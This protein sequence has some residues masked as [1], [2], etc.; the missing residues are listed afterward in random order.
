MSVRDDVLA[1]LRDPAAFAAIA[2]DPGVWLA[3]L[4]GFALPSIAAS[5]DRPLRPAQ[6]AAWR[7]LADC[8]AGLILGPPGTGKTHLLS[9]LIAGYGEARIRAGL[10]AQTFVTAFTRNAAANVLEGV[11]ERQALHLPGAPA[12]IY[13]G[14]PPDSGLP[15]GVDG[16][17]RGEE[18]TLREALDSG[19]AV[20]GG[21][22]WSLYR[23]LAADGAGMTAQL[24][25]LVCIDEASQ[26]VLGQGLMALAGLAADGRVVVAGDDQQ[27]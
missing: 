18:R 23:L 17:R 24:F 21:T 13:Y 26:M 27:L 6:E 12:P 3:G 5:D 25:D 8:R 15:P 20:V 22:I 2:T 7:G 1:F 14:A 10:P 11:A 19:R 4:E 16:L 9:W